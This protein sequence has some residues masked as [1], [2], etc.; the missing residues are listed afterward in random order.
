MHYDYL[1]WLGKSKKKNVSKKYH[2]TLKL[3]CSQSKVDLTN[4]KCQ[5][6]KNK[7]FTH[8]TLIGHNNLP[9]DFFVIISK[10]KIGL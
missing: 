5:N 4:Q 10:L 3:Q 9:Q 7:I 6:F 8:F 1:G 2:T